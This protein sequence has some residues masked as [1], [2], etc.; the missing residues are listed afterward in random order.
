VTVKGTLA[1]IS[2]TT[3][4]VLILFLF[5][6]TPARA[7]ARWVAFDGGRSEAKVKV[8]VAFSNMREVVVDLK[9]PGMHVR[10]RKE[11]GVTYQLVKIGKA[12]HTTQ[13]G[14]PELPMIGRFLAVPTGAR[15]AVQVVDYTF[16]EIKDYHIYPAQEPQ[17]E[18]KDAPV[19]GFKIDGQL[20]RRNAFYPAEI[21]QLEG[22]VIIRGYSVVILRVFPVQFNPAKKRIRVYANIKLK[23]TFEGGTETFVPHG[24]RSPSFERILGRLLLNSPEVALEEA[25]RAAYEDGSSLLIITHPDFLAAANT[26]AQWKVKKGIRTEVRTTSETGSTAALIKAYIQNTY[27]TWSPP[28]THVLFIGDAEYIPC[29]YVT[30]H[31]YGSSQGY[32]GTDLYYATVD[33]TDYFPDIALGRLSVDTAQEADKRV[34]DIITYEK[35]PVTDED[36]YTH[37]ACAAYFQDDDT[38]GYADRRLALTSEDIRNYLVSAGYGVERIYYT[39]PA[40]APRYW[41][42]SYWPYTGDPIPAELRKPTFAWNGDRYD[43]DNEVH[44]GVFLLTHRDHGSTLGWA[45]PYYRTYHVQALTNGDRLPVVWS[46]NCQTGWFDNE[47]DD[48]STSTSSSAVHFS[49]AWERNPNGGAIG[50]IGATRVSYSGHNDRL[51]WGFMDGIWPD[52][53]PIYN[54][55]GTPFDHPLWEM[56]AVLNY[57]KYYYATVYSDSTHRKIGFEMFH[58]FGDPTME[59]W[60]DVPQDLDV[61]HDPQAGE[62]ATS[63]EV[64]VA[65]PGA[66]ICIS[67]DGEILGRVISTGG[68]TTISWPTPLLSGEVIQITVTKHNYRPYEGAALAGNICQCDLNNDSKCDMEDWLIFGQ[69]WG[70]I[71][72]NDPGV[73]PCDCDLTGDGLCDMQDWLVFGQDWGRTDCP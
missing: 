44:A 66:L 4:A 46:I 40:V 21:V 20:Y 50:I 67:K 17:P 68:T 41:S 71:D 56:G 11:K 9:I 54:P 8:N 28:P 58:W 48:A 51:A 15:A 27:D 45:E 16:K 19:R 61:S 65:Q 55:S 13:I 26:L 64:S 33:G 22:P 62:G 7:A 2:W 23:V 63:F 1:G 6:A 14:K 12:G 35:D 47:T 49:E 72:C 38:N 3:T 24:L 53:E 39:D 34:A 73:D 43:I 29:H 52:F 59:I 36:Y 25:Y 69:G 70:R 5:L 31:P 32:V 37:A 60:T 18:V 42:T 30:D 10:E 57:G